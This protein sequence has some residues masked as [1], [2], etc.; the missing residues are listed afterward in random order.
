[1]LFYIKF[2]ACVVD[3]IYMQYK[4]HKYAVFF[5]AYMLHVHIR[6]S[7]TAEGPHNALC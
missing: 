4:L 7:A 6:S 3:Y 5:R 1:L 2:P